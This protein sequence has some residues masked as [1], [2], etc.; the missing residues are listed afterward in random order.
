[1]TSNFFSVNLT[2]LQV[3]TDLQSLEIWVNKNRMTLATDKCAKVTFRGKD[4]IFKLFGE[5]LKTEAN[6]RDLGITLTSD[7]T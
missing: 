5:P 6:V 1:M 3:Q 7:L 4:I 2:E